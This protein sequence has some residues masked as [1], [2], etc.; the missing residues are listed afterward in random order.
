MISPTY[1]IRQFEKDKNIIDEHIQ[2]NEINTYLADN[3][4]IDLDFAI[5]A[6]KE[7]IKL[8]PNHNQQKT[9]R[10]Q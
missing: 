10:N 9:N 8:E 2:K 3:L 6:L 7:L 4:K 5:E 1:L